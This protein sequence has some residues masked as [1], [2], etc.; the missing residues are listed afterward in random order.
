MNKSN[1]PPQG[2]QKLAES[3][4]QRGLTEGNASGVRATGTL[5]LELALSGLDRIREKARRDKRVRFTALLHHIDVAQLRESYLNLNRSAGAGVDGVG[6]VSYTH[7]RA[8][9]DKRQSRMPYSA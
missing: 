3:V 5:N 6:S 1:H 2:G 8:H 7:L 4:E 9:R